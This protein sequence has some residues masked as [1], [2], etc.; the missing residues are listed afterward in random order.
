[1]L[2]PRAPVALVGSGEFLPVMEEVDRELL[3]G[4]PPVLAF[5]PPAAG[6]EGPSRIQYWLRL[7]E[8]HARRL[9][10]EPVPVPVLDRADA[11]RTDLADRLAGA[12]L[13]YLSGGNP[14]YLADTLRKSPVLDAIVAAWEG[15]AALA[16]CSAGAAALSEVAHELPTDVRRLG[17]GLV[18]RLV[19]IP[20]FDQVEHRA[21]EIIGRSVSSLTDGQLLVGID[22][23][24]ALVGGPD[25]WRVRGR[26]RVSVIDTEGRR[27]VHPTD[28]ELTIAAEPD[29]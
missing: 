17:L 23:N 6:Q 27:H 2:R 18:R 19:V 12:G 26:G 3:A 4:R 8:S 16:G 13:V 10:V 5:L 7:A 22:E 20:P 1:M 15:G 25:R 21:P 28:T 29:A 24:T 11:E 14:G 9:G